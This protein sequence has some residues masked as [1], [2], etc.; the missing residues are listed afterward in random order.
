[1]VNI[2]SVYNSLLI[3]IFVAFSA[4][5]KASFKRLKRKKEKDA[6]SMAF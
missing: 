2:L 3:F 4:R 1:M 6:M 5:E